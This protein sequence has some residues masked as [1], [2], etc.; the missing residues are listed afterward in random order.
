MAGLLKEVGCWQAFV[1]TSLT[2]SAD[3]GLMMPDG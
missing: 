3:T 2:F 1:I